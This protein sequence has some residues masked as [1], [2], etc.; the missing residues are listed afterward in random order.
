MNVSASQPL[1]GRKIARLINHH[2]IP[3][4]LVVGKY[5]KVIKPANM[6][7]LLKKLDHYTFETPEAGHTGLI[8]ASGIY[9]GK[10]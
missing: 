1:A 10:M 8:A 7:P 2:H 9:F 5:D 3:L 4:T 6:N